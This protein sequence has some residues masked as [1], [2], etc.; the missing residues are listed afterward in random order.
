MSACFVFCCTISILP[1][2]STE[3]Q[4]CS[5]GTLTDGAEDCCYGLVKIGNICK[6]CP[7][8]YFGANCSTPCP[9]HMYG[10]GCTQKCTCSHCHPV[11]GCGAMNDTATKTFRTFE[12]LTSISDEV[13]DSKP[14]MD[15]KTQEPSRMVT[16]YAPG[17]VRDLKRII[18]ISCGTLISLALLLLMVREIRRY[19]LL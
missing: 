12:L 4:M 5:T 8:G 1:M 3:G 17:E 6:A 14:K 13:N 11:F 9:P 7:A 16:I 10:S 18:I 2:F 19:T 15:T